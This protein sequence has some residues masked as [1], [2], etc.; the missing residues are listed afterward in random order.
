MASAS[1]PHAVVSEPSSR[2]TRPRARWVVAAVCMALAACGGTRSVETTSHPAEVGPTDEVSRRPGPACQ[3]MRAAARALTCGETDDCESEALP[4][5]WVLDLDG[6]GADDHVR[7]TGERERA[8]LQ[9]RFA[10][11]Q[12]DVVGQTPVAMTGYREPDDVGRTMAGGFSWIVAWMVAPRADDGVR[13]RGRL[14]EPMPGRGDGL[15]MSGGDAAAV[16]VLT[17][18]GWL[19]VELGY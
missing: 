9:V 12:T 18:D 16:L 8:H 3:A 17:E 10:N 19:L 4:C 1:L 15:W 2:R 7:V 14:F 6:D 5:S 13:V 11:G